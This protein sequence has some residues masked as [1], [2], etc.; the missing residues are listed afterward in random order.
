MG[1]NKQN[2]P[3]PNTGPVYRATGNAGDVATAKPANP[4]RKNAKREIF[5]WVRAF[6]IAILIAVFISQV[7]VVNARVP[8]ASMVPTIYPKDRVLGLRTSYWF[9]VAQRG[10]IVIFKFPDD[11]KQLY[12]KRVVGLP[13]ET[14]SFADGAVYINGQQFDESAYLAPGQKTYENAMNPGPFTVP[15]GH[16]FVMGDNRS[17]SYDSRYWGNTYVAEEK[18][19]GKAAL[20]L[21]P[22]PGV[23]R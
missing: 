3:A 6:V 17:D 8:S 10:D 14:V 13:G 18:I 4:K 1:D 9:D 20:R 23:L 2:G 5:E 7:L 21:F 19:V 16:Y 12:V 15:E 22:N 11:E